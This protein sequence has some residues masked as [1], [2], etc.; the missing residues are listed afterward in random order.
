[1]GV[2]L[3]GLRAVLGSSGDELVVTPYVALGALVLLAASLMISIFASVE[4]SA[5]F[6]MPWLRLGDLAVYG[7]RA[8]KRGAAPGDQLSSNSARLPKEDRPSKTI[9]VLAREHGLEGKH[10]DYIALATA[11]WPTE[12]DV[13]EAEDLLIYLRQPSGR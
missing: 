12:Q 9:D 11:V 4:F 8:T 13:R 10:P 6:V 7:R 5:A 1:V 2:G 3:D